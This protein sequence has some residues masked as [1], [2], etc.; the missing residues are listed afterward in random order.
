MRRIGAVVFLGLCGPLAC[1]KPAL[2]REDVGDTDAESDDGVVGPVEVDSTEPISCRSDTDCGDLDGPCSRGVCSTSKRCEAR[3]LSNVACDDEDPCTRDDV[4]TDGLCKGDAF[5]CDDGLSC[6]D[7]VCDGRGGCSFPV[8]SGRCFIEGT[9]HDAGTP[10]PTI[11]CRVCVEGRAWSLLDGG[12]CDDGDECTLAT[13]CEAGVCGHGHAPDDAPG[14]F[15]KV[16]ARVAQPIHELELVGLVPR[17]AGGVYATLRVRGTLILGDDLEFA[18]PDA[19]HVIVALDALGGVRGAW[20]ITGGGTPTVLGDDLAGRLMWSDLCEGCEITDLVSHTSVQ[21]ETTFDRPAVLVRA[22][23]GAVLEA[24][25]L[26]H[27]PEA[28]DALDRTYFRVKVTADEVFVRGE[29]VSTLVLRSGNEAASLSL[30]RLSGSYVPELLD[31]IKFSPDVQT[32]W[33]QFDVDVGPLRV[34]SDGAVVLPLVV[35]SGNLSTNL[36]IFGTPVTSNTLVVGVYRPSLGFELIRSIAQLDNPLGFALLGQFDVAAVG[37]EVT[38][39]GRFAGQTILVGESPGSQSYQSNQHWGLEGSGTFGAGQEGLVARLSS[40]ELHWFR[41]VRTQ[42]HPSGS[43]ESGTF[44]EQLVTS[45]HVVY[46]LG[47]V[48]GLGAIA[49]GNTLTTIEPP[50]ED[51]PYRVYNILVV[52]G[53]DGDLRYVASVE[54]RTAAIAESDGLMF[55]AGRLQPGTNGV[56]PSRIVDPQLEVSTPRLYIQRFNSAGGLSCGAGP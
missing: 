16:F 37:Q 11:P 4:C 9:C 15:L 17:E 47:G 40:S 20:A 54:G 46:A 18:S 29:G 2:P 33:P 22:R 12:P 23:S 6:T 53:K 51:A 27:A 49:A 44:F 1:F 34:M 30:I 50:S 39:A 38:I 10:H 55:L 32:L 42:G 45:G 7:D 3:P 35:G 56:G 52:F 13:T 41:T 19:A 8:A 14:D 31:Q 24:R 28:K 43:G 36:S 48:S 21:P 26:S 25:P 5:T